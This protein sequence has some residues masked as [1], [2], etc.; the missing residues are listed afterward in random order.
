MENQVKQWTDEQARE[1]V[2]Y[3]RA[4]IARVITDPGELRTQ[5]L[6]ALR[7]AESEPCFMEIFLRECIPD[8]RLTEFIRLWREWRKERQHGHTDTQ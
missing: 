3:L 1:D 2:A 5:F 8:K 6:T 7:K 4:Y